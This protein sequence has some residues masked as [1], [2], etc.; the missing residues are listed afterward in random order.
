MSFD[1][2]VL[3]SPGLCGAHPW[4]RGLSRAPAVAETL[5]DQR[6]ILRGC[7]TLCSTTPVCA[8][9][10]ALTW[11]F[12]EDEA[13]LSIN[14][15]RYSTSIA[16]QRGTC[17]CSMPNKPLSSI[18]VS[19]LRN[20]C[21]Q[22]RWVMLQRYV[23]DLVNMEHRR[24]FLV[25]TRRVMVNIAVMFTTGSTSRCEQTVAFRAQLGCSNQYPQTSPD[26]SSTTSA[27]RA[28]PMSPQNHSTVP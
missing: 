3:N 12:E 1:P 19:Q 23:N 9:S 21:S 24:P 14:R 7:H 28:S 13:R 18:V 27:S 5:Q 20:R 2:T 10:H 6:L 22:L 26:P 8:G 16:G 25:D 11:T 17:E 4:N 15:I